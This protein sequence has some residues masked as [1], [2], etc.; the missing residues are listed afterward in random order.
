ML[1][2]WTIIL[3]FPLLNFIESAPT[4]AATKILT[5]KTKHNQGNGEYLRDDKMTKDLEQQHWISF[6]DQND[7]GRKFSVSDMRFR[8]SPQSQ[9]VLS[10]LL[11]NDPDCPQY[12]DR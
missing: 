10:V 9:D 4:T 6:Q 1:L 12:K 7:Q 3:V 8:R 5:D 2:L 11:R